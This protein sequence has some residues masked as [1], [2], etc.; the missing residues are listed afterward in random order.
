[1]DCRSSSGPARV[2]RLHRF[3]TF[4][5]PPRNGEVRPQADTSAGAISKAAPTT[6]RD[7]SRPINGT[8]MAARYP[9]DRAMQ[10]AGQ[11]SDRHHATAATA[12]TI[13]GSGPENRLP[14]QDSGT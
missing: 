5:P 7:R 14:R 1:V 6:T 11:R 9:R 4:S 10:L 8:G 12:A 13:A 2:A 3:Q